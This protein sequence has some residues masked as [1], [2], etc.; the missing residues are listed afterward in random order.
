M[1][2][3]R[4]DLVDITLPAFFKQTTMNKTLFIILTLL[5]FSCKDKD[6]GQEQKIFDRIEFVYDLKQVV[7]EKT[8]V[9]F[10]N[11]EYDVPLIYFTDT[12]SYVANPTEK[13]LNT[14]K[15]DLVFQN[16]LIK[17]YKT[18]NR[19]DIIPF[20]METVMNLGDST[21][22]NYHSPFMMCSSYEETYKTIPD[23]LSTEEWATMIMH[24]YFHGYQLKHKSFVNYYEQEIVH[25]QK[26]S[27]KGIYKNN[28]WFKK[29]IDKENELLL[30][31]ISEIDYLKTKDLIH[32]FFA[33][34]NQRRNSVFENLK[35]DISKYEKFYETM[36]GTARYIEHSLYGIYSTSQ[37][38]NKLLMS[39]HFFKSFEK[40]RNYDIKKDEWLYLTEKTTYFYAIGFN[41]ARLLDKLKIEYKSRLFKEGEITMEDILLEKQNGW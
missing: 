26:D 34:R 10:N 33:L 11:K 5:V 17:I 28:S 29:S 22:Y 27:L 39:D 31:A 36:E 19:V 24:E 4:L 20:Y 35:I 41:M 23:V 30:E 14:F 21:D 16:R 38:D 8:W 9:N 13:F 32:Q 2:K 7:E 15:S 6:Y 3:G 12:S 37:P 18:E 40:F 1:L 25:F